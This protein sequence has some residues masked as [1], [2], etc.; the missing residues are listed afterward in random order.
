MNNLDGPQTVC[1]E[2]TIAVV[3]EALPTSRADGLTGLT[4]ECKEKVQIVDRVE[5]CRKNLIGENEV[6]QVGLR[7]V[8]AGVAIAF[9]IKRRRVFFEFH[10]LDRNFAVPG[11]DRAI[12][13]DAR[14]Q[15][16]VKHVDATIDRDN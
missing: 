1:C 8:E 6:S 9:R 5:P 7:I 12:S 3:P 10:A 16:A 14:W 2:A 15:N 4:H 13:C 11:V